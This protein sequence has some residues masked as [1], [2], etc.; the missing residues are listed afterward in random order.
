MSKTLNGLQIFSSILFHHIWIDL[1]NS[2]RVNG[3]HID[4]HKPILE[5]EEVISQQI[6]G[7]LARFFSN[8]SFFLNNTKVNQCFQILR[9][10]R[11]LLTD[12]HLDTIHSKSAFSNRFD[13]SI[14]NGR[15]P[16]FLF[17]QISR[18]L[19][20]IA[21][22]VKEIIQQS[23]IHTISHIQLV[24]IVRNASR[25]SL[26]STWLSIKLIDEPQRIRYIFD[27]VHL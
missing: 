8:R 14:I 20:Q 23:L 17:Q 15:L 4:R 12:F 18:L 26:P 16:E 13:D 21:G 1:C 24:D 7:F 11:I 10:D 3:T 6:D 27:S 22:T 9:Y 19:I 25:L 5:S 2:T